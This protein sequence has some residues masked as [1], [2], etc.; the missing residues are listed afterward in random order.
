[1]AHAGEELRLVLTCFREL[2]VLLLDFI[3]KPD[4]LDRDHCLVGKGCDQRDLGVSERPY[5]VAR[6][7]DNANRYAFAHER[8]AEHS[9]ESANSLDFDQSVFWL[10]QNIGHLD[11]ST[12]EH[13]TP[14]HRPAARYNGMSS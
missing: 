4:V 6:Q 7:H 9:A 8:H 10:G 14:E 11:G 5:D 1:M 13:R 3:E 2:A 12:F